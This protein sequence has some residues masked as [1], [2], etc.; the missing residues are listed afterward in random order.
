MEKLDFKK[1][2]NNSNIEDDLKLEKE[3][4]RLSLRKKKITSII[5]SKRK[6]LYNI[7]NA[8]DNKEKYT[9]EPKEIKIPNECQIDIPKFLDNVRTTFIFILII[10]IVQYF[11]IKRIFKFS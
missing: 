9:I 8:N 6:I 4:I 3:E 7:Q 11:A 10:F 5:S 1:N 2:K